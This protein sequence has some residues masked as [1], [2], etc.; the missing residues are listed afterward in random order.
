[1]DRG[2]TLSRWLEVERPATAVIAMAYEVFS[3][4]ALLHESG[5]VHRDIKPANL[6]FVLLTQQWRLL[7]LGIVAPIG[8]AQP[9]CQQ[10]TVGHSCLGA[11]LC[12]A[13]D[14]GTQA[15]CLWHILPSCFMHCY[16][17]QAVLNLHV[18]FL[19]AYHTVLMLT[20]LNCSYDVSEKCVSDGSICTVEISLP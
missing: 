16:A 18:L 10:E 9:H 3:M 7:D 4:L 20:R 17:T 11:T 15:C 2:V 6:L 5:S 19:L 12:Q 8:M 1:M 14:I 13:T